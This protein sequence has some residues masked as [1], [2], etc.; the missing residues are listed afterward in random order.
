[1]NKYRVLA[2]NTVGTMALREEAN[3]TSVDVEFA[4]KNFNR[5]ITINDD[6]GAC[7]GALSYSGMMLA[8]RGEE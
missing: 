8:S 4:N 3:F 5:N 2:W 6:F 1:M 7:M